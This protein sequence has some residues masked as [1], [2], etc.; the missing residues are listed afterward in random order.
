[1]AKTRKPTQDL[2]MPGAAGW[3]RWTGSPGEPCQHE[4]QLGHN[5]LAFAREAQSRV[6]A[7]PLAH[8]WVLPAWLQGDD[9][10]LR[11]MAALHLERLG[12]RVADLEH[13]LQVRKVASKDGAHLV[14]MTAL[15]EAALPSLDLA[16]LPDE[17]VLSADCLPIPADAM[18]ICRELGKL[19]LMISRGHEWVYASPLSAGEL[20][21]DALGEVNHLCLQL[22]FQGVLGQI[23][24]IILWLAEEGNL[25]Q[26]RQVTG[27]TAL[28]EPKPQPVMPQLGRSTLVPSDLLEARKK[29]ASAA[30]TR[31]MALSL[32]FVAAAVIAGVTVL[33]VWA[34]QERDMLRERVA[35]LTPRASQVMDQKK[36]WL[37]ASPAVDPSFFPMQVL[38]DSMEPSAS[39]EVSMTHFEW[40][41]DR[42]LLR[43]RTP[44]PALA[45]QYAKEITEVTGL[46]RYNWETPPPDI[47]S[48]NSATFELKG[49]LKP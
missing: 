26:I 17:I 8:F 34:T 43:G 12:V 39:P 36:S 5:T 47:A 41:P 38:L 15:K 35:E 28:R 46:S 22:G 6:L 24:H 21:A 18:V 13:G 27:L 9:A 7:L 16:L 14:C 44:S 2:L 19:V 48:D 32:G 1:M 30:R 29:G 10:H 4:A 20:N 3:E 25:E 23:Q 31:V 45:L 37:E 33:T 40:T 11:D 42:L 49:G